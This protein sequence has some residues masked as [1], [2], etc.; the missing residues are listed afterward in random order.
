M[1]PTRIRFSVS[2]CLGVLCVFVVNSSAAQRIN[3]P[4]VTRAAWPNG[5]RVVLMEYHRA[6]TLTV[7]ALFSGGS[8]GDPEG[9]AGV[10]GLTAGLL[11][12][13]TEKRTALQIAEEIEFLGGSLDSSAGDDRIAVS[14]NVLAKDADAGLDLF[15]DIIRHPT[16]PAAELERERRL[17]VA[18]LESL[19]EDPGAVA[20]RVATEVIYAGHPYG[21]EATIASLKAIT[22]DDLTACYRRI[23]APG[24][25]IL[26]A[27]GDFKTADMMAKLRARFGDW[28]SPIPLLR[29]EG[30]KREPP[31]PYEGGGWGEVSDDGGGRGEV[32]PVKPGP[33]RVVLIDKPDATQTQVRFGRTAFPRRSPDYLPAQVADTILGGGFTSRLTE[34][35]RINRSLT[36]SVGTEFDAKARGGDFTLSTFTKIETTRALIDATRAVLKRAAAQ[37]FTPAELQKVKGYLAGMFAIRVQTPEALAAQLADIAFYGLPDDY[38]QTYLPRLR[39]VTLAR[40]NRVARTYFPPDGLSLILV[41]PAAKVAGQLK[42]LGNIETRPVESVGK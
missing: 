36:Y 38:L 25:M 41:A 40:I 30:G 1:I 39:A 34:A 12:R 13:G 27:V 21:I 31:P 37:G 20:D 4:T 42:G 6:P 9:K 15:A 11:R 32:P 22:Q 14:L 16:F 29:K 19:A 28:T 7:T 17:A 18:G 3:L 2:V 24:R 5:A 10:A 8:A 23:L 33:R 26:V 35:I